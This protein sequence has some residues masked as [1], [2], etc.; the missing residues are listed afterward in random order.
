[1][2]SRRR[3]AD[4]DAQNRASYQSTPALWKPAMSALVQKQTSALH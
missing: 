4:P 3:I 2:N 1:M